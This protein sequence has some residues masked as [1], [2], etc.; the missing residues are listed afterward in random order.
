MKNDLLQILGI[1]PELPLETIRE[2]LEE[3]NLE[4]LERLDACEDEEQAAQLRTVQKEIEAAIQACRDGTF[5]KPKKRAAAKPKQPPQASSALQEGVRR[6]KAGDMAGALEALRGEAEQGEPMACILT[7]QVYK[8]QGD[9]E[10]CRRHLFYAAKRDSGEAALMLA[11]NYFEAE[12]TDQALKWAERAHELRAA[13]AGQLLIRLL[14]SRNQWEKALR[15]AGE[16]LEWL[17]DY[18]RYALC[19]DIRTLLD[20][21]HYSDEKIVELV[22]PMVE[23]LANDTVSQ[24]V[25]DEPYQIALDK[26]RQRQAKLEQERKK[27]ELEEK[28]RQEAEEAE[29]EKREIAAQEAARKKKQ[30]N[31]LTAVFVLFL[32]AL[33]AGSYFYLAVLR[34]AKQY[35]TAEELLATKDYV[36]AETIFAALGDYEDAAQRLQGVQ[37]THYSVAAAMQMEGR[38]A[39]AAVTY[40][41]LGD[42]KDARQRSQELWLQVYPYSIAVERSG[43]VAAVTADGG[44]VGWHSQEGW[45]DIAA[46]AVS[47]DRLLGLKT[48]GTVVTT[49]DNKEINKAVEDWT[50]IVA[51]A[52][53][54]VHDVG[55][56]SD[57]TVVATGENEK[58]QCEVS[59]WKNIVAVAAND[60]CTVGLR[61]DGTVITTTREC[62]DWT[63]IKAIA[64]GDRFILGL[65]EDGTVAIAG[66]DEELTENVSGWESVASI[67]AGKNHAVGFRWDCSVVA[68]GENDREQCEVSGWNVAGAVA[69]GNATIGLQWDGTA[70]AA[71]NGSISSEWSDLR[72]PGILWMDEAA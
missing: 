31:I 41:Q 10:N 34:P 30:K 59:G 47:Q 44:V 71:G 62:G 9:N 26:E 13:G 19:G 57:G 54:G 4:Y 45:S 63:Q 65:R 52:G 39:A 15:I 32:A 24:R 12:E 51:I 48:N 29:R 20:G 37:R 27:K 33:A 40:G 16:E 22:G 14:S 8:S 69:G 25:L 55:L 5:S 61:G 70:V 43:N 60:R 6:F 42:Y 7:A 56:R 21:K 50:G 11:Q 64:C 17:P 66:A 58:R 28:R 49:G 18:E 38:I 36:G 53:S 2:E 23:L 46:I 3:K 68:A 35:E 67:S 1:D 72:M